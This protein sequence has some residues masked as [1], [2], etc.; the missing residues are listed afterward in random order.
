MV[1]K[2]IFKKKSKKKI[3]TSINNTEIKSSNKKINQDYKVLFLG[4]ITIQ[5]GP[6]YFVYTAKKILEEM[7]NV[8]FYVAG[9]GDMMERMVNLSKEMGLEKKMVFTGFLKG[10]EV[11]EMYQKCDVYI[12]PSVSEPFGIAP[13]EAAA[14]NCATVISKQSGVAEIFKNSL[15]VDY[16]DVDETANKVVGL[17]KNDDI[18]KE[19]IKNAKKEINEINWDVAATKVLNV[20]KEVLGTF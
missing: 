16:W 6:E 5:K 12:M 19:L 1:Y 4:R 9:S 13:L 8:T 20:Y 14:N 17:L 18:R 7:E 15:K 3:K 10:K 11:D 2:M